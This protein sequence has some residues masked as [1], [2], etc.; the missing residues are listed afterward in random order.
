MSEIKTHA[1]PKGRPKMNVKKFCVSILDD[2]LAV[3]KKAGFGSVSQGIRFATYL[4]RKS[5]GS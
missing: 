1:K 3:L 4:L 2:D 5:S